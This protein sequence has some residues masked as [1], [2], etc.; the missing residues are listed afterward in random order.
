MIESRRPARAS[1]YAY[2]IGSPNLL[3]DDE[4]TARAIATR[5]VATITTSR[6]KARPRS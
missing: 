6:S 5:L 3:T 1:R 4:L 2:R